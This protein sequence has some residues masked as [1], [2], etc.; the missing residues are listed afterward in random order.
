MPD[1][2][3]G[4]GRELTER[5][6]LRVGRDLACPYDKQCISV[7]P[8]NEVLEA[9]ATHCLHA[10]RVIG[11]NTCQHITLFARPPIM[12]VGFDPRDSFRTFSVHTVAQPFSFISPV[13]KSTGHLAGVARPPEA[14]PKVCLEK[15]S[16]LALKFPNFGL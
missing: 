4:S 14:P 3:L 15:S 6:Q 1:S 2:E 5:R 7:T 8:G 16:N 10:D 13:T 12:K 9:R 11:R